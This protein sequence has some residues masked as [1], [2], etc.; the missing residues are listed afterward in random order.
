MRAIKVRQLVYCLK[1]AYIH[2]KTT[3]QRR[4]KKYIFFAA[5]KIQSLVRGFLAR[6]NRLPYKKATKGR[7][8][9]LEAVALG[10]KVRRIFKLKE[11]QMRVH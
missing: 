2:V 1:N 9:K 5:T 7:A 11:V 6:K 10:W 4:L 3:K 8:A